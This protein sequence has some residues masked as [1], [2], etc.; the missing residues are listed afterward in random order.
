LSPDDIDIHGRLA[1]ST[2]VTVATGEI[3]YGRWRHKEL[4]EKKAAAILQTDAAVCGGITEFRR[5]AATAD[6]H[7]ITLCPHWFHD[8]H[9]HLVGS[10]PNGRF[11]EYFPDDQVLNFRRLITRQLEI[12][13]EGC[14]LLPNLPGLGFDFDPD[15]VEQWTMDGWK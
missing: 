13:D 11:V 10:I 3:E 12:G 7:G 15:A 6:S 14:L 4:I 1:A 2:P 8:L 9:I 5:I